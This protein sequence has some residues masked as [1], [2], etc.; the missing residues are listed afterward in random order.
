MPDRVVLD[1]SVA[2]E[3]VVPGDFSRQALRLLAD[4]RDRKVVLLAPTLWAYEVTSALRKQTCAG[5]V[6]AVQAGLA[7][8]RLLRLEV[9]LVPPSADL[10]RRAI[11]WSARTNQRA[12]YDAAYLAVT[13]HVDGTFWTLDRRLFEAARGAGASWVYHVGTDE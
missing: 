3:L 6:D 9:E 8:D 7:L 10:Q 1:A 4:W 5:R 12:A 11:W 13:E 2:V